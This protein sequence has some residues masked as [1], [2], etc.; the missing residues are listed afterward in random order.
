MGLDVYLYHC[1][2]R[3][4]AIA[5][6]QRASNAVNAVWDSI[7]KD[8]NLMTEEDKEKLIKGQRTVYENEGCDVDGTHNSVTQVEL[9]SKLYPEHLFKIGYFRSSYNSA[10]I[11]S[12]FRRLGLKDLYQIMDMQDDQAEVHHDWAKCL[13]NIDQAIEDFQNHLDSS[14]GK[15]NIIALRTMAVDPV[16]SEL[17]AF[18]VFE[19]EIT[20]D[21]KSGFSSYS[22]S[23]G[24]FYLD[25]LKVHA[26]IPSSQCGVSMYAVTSKDNTDKEDWYMQALKIMR[27][28]CEYVLAQNDPQN[29]YMYWSG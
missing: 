2:N 5:A 6:E 19:N 26:F 17:E 8:Y 15:Y 23:K 24:D 27:E 10:G 12:V 3:P 25:G 9:A 20:K 16:A 1:K 7:G 18:K 28:T 4:A 22:S 14:L 11:N 29:Y 21:Y 13:K